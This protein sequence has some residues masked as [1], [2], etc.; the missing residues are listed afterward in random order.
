MNYYKTL[1]STFNNIF[2]I[3]QSIIGLVYP[4]QNNVYKQ[5][6]GA[7]GQFGLLPFQ[8]IDKGVSLSEV[9]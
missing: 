7:R 3:D 6:R 4:L 1:H 8:S 2:K 5:T 9:W